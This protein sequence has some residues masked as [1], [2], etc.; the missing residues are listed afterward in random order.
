[1]WAR[2]LPQL[3]PSQRL[4]LLSLAFK[5][6]DNEQ[7][8]AVKYSEL[9]TETGLSRRTLMRVIS[10]LKSVGLLFV[11]QRK[12]RGSFLPN[13]YRLATKITTEIDEGGWCHDDTRGGDMV[14]LGWCHSDPL[15]IYI[16]N[17]KNN[18]NISANV[19]AAEAA[20][21][22]MNIRDVLKNR[23]EEIE[24]EEI[25]EARKLASA[26]RKSHAKYHGD[27]LAEFTMKVLGMFKSME[28]RGATNQVILDVVRDWS[29]WIVYT[30][31]N[32]DAFKLPKQP[33]P[34]VLLKYIESAIR[35]SESLNP[36]EV[37]EPEI[38]TAVVE[39]VRRGTLPSYEVNKDL[40]DVFK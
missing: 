26:Y 5:A 12:Y 11:R 9:G 6:D 38:V 10:H 24:D 21:S 17:N 23:F 35:Y 7:T 15:S 25:L 27:F 16:N 22:N 34:P 32:T 28:K 39:P 31:K 18:K 14:T 13:E 37:V 40:L 29:A 1:V 2:S 19:S 33:N 8:C 3:T 4:V 30:E 20:R 36:E